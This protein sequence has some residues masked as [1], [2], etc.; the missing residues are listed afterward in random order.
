[1]KTPKFSMLFFFVSRKNQKP[2]DCFE[3][4]TAYVEPFLALEK[5]YTDFPELTPQDKQRQ[6]SLH[7]H[8]VKSYERC[9]RNKDTACQ[10]DKRPAMEIELWLTLCYT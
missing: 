7:R 1:M 6:S 9:H 8:H 4:D 10:V 3:Q 5:K 2:E